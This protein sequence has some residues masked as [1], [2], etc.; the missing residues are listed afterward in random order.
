V[1]DSDDRSLMALAYQWVYRITGVALEMVLPGLAGCWLDRQLGTL[2][3]FA[4]LGFAGG[5]TLGIW[6]LLAMTRADAA[7]RND[8]GS[9]EGT[10][11]R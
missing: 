4:M 5:M 10:G 3:L 8:P 6:H 7:D 1:A 2:V 9:E 11:N